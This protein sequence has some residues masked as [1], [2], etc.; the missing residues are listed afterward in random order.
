M[1]F[2]GI[3]QKRSASFFGMMNN[4]DPACAVRTRKKEAAAMGGRALLLGFE[5]AA[6]AQLAGVFSAFGFDAVAAPWKGFAPRS[7]GRNR[8]KLV[9]A[10]M[11]DP[12]AASMESLARELRRLWG[13]FLPILAISST[14]RFQDVAALLDA[15]A[16]DCLPVSAPPELIKRKIVRCLERGRIPAVSEVDEELPAGL[17]RVFAENDDLVPLGEL[18][19][20]YP[21][22]VPRRPVWRR[23]AP[24]DNNWRGVMTA[25]EVGR[26]YAGK[27]GSYLSWS[28]LH[29]FRLPAPAEYEAAEKVLL[30]RIG[31]PLAAAVDRS[32]LP[33]GAG[34]YALVPRDGVAAGYVACLLNS[35]LLDFYCN[36]LAPPGHGG[37][38]RPEDVRA[39]PVPLPTAA[40]MQE[41][42]RAAALLA[43]YGPNPGHWADRQSRDAL[44][45]QME[46]TVLSLYGAGE[47]VRDEL[48]ALHF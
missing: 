31:P 18:T 47:D 16:D 1:R 5:N 6:A 45:E 22:A 14:R 7:F 2:V 12:A 26:F 41:L 36:R 25:D 37:R 48:A 11:D 19:D 9:A 44:L 10:F 29:L 42:S 23:M 35:R 20:V 34:V 27:P 33:A 17:L 15:G 46:T 13:E 43:H 40:A 32:R 3:S 30:R 4:D 28:R 8:P 21:G 39:I 38:L 24:P